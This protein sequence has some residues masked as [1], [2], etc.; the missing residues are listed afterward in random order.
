MTVQAIIGLLL[1]EYA[2]SVTKRQ[3]KRNKEREAKFHSYVRLDAGKW[4]RWKLYPGALLLM[5]TRLLLVL[6]SMILLAIIASMLTCCRDFKK[7]GPIRQGC[8][9]SCIQFFY[10]LLGNF[11]CMIFGTW[12]TIK[13]AEVDYSYY[14]GP[15]YKN[16]MRDIKKTSTIIA[17]HVSL[18]DGLIL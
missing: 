10:R 5:P 13:H 7:K 3:Q 15:N 17:N 4:S 16:T 11:L 18:L 9:K 1:F 6:V 12:S 2:W 14:L 8:Q